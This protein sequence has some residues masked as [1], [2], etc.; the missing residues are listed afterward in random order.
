MESKFAISLFKEVSPLIHVHCCHTAQPVMSTSRIRVI[1][2]VYTVKKHAMLMIVA[3][4]QAA[5]SKYSTVILV[6]FSA[7][8]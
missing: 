2:I 8:F 3:S 4:F 1:D 7:A 6:H 5:C